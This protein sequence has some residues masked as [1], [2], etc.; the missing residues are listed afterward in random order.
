M[1]ATAKAR[2]VLDI[3]ERIAAA[4]DGHRDDQDDDQD[5]DQGE[6]R[7]DVLADILD[8]SEEAQAQLAAALTVRAVKV[9][10]KAQNDDEAAALGA[11]ILRALAAHT[12]AEA[13]RGLMDS[14]DL[15]SFVNVSEDFEEGGGDE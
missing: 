6:T 12:Q 13:V 15:S 8:A 2:E 14:P 1:T 4:F 11:V 3:F 9:A 7:D 5:D 10:A